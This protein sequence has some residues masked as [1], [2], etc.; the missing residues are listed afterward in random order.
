MA[1]FF[2]LTKHKSNTSPLPRVKNQWQRNDTTFLPMKSAKTDRAPIHSPPKAAAVGIYLI[3][4]KNQTEKHLWEILCR[5]WWQHSKFKD[6]TCS[7]HEPWICPCGHASPSAVPSTAWQPKTCYLQ[8]QLSTTRSHVHVHCSSISRVLCLW[9]GGH[10]WNS[11]HKKTR[12]LK[13][14]S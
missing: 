8:C 3:K 9:M 10:G 14:L 7:A 12:S 2:K 1:P 5:F 11:G 13:R 6:N 4:T